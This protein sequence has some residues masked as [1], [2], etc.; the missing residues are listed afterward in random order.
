MKR[1]KLHPVSAE[2]KRVG[3]AFYCP[4]C[5]RGHIFYISGPM[6]WSFNGDQEKPT[7]SPSLLLFTPEHRD[8]DT[9]KKIPR[10]VVC[11]LFLSAGR[12]QFCGDCPHELAGQVVPMVDW[13]ESYAVD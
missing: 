13:P 2:G 6:T 5:K 7:F 8:V 10:A 11:H 9:G 3:W 12:I 4:A 1:Q